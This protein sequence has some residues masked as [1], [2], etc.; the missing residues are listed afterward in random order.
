MSTTVPPSW[1]S[2]TAERSLGRFLLAFVGGLFFFS[3]CSLPFTLCEGIQLFVWLV[4]FLFLYIIHIYI[5][6]TSKHVARL[7][8]RTR[9]FRAR[10]TAEEMGK[11][12]VWGLFWIKPGGALGVSPRLENRDST[13]VSSLVGEVVRRA[14]FVL[15]LRFCPSVLEVTRAAPPCLRVNS[16]PRFPSRLSRQKAGV[17][18]LW[19]FGPSAAHFTHLP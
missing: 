13:R 8:V 11:M 17:A 15:L 1:G 6:Y 4:F 10:L 19:D 14:F 3:K 16:I 2:E 9:V 18:D 12:C 7:C 5:L